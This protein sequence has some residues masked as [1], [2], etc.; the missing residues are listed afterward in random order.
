[1][2]CVCDIIYLFIYV[3]TSARYD[4]PLAIS[5]HI[6]AEA[7]GCECVGEPWPSTLARSCP[8]IFQIFAELCKSG[9]AVLIRSHSPG[10]GIR[11]PASTRTS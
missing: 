8:L 1:M 3:L 10:L 6:V 5:C 11:I 9:L 2:L 7:G 4:P